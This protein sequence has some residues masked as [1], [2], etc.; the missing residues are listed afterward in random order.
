MDNKPDNHPDN[1][2]ANNKTGL[3]RELLP[4]VIIDL[5]PKLANL[6]I[7]YILRLNSDSRVV[8]DYIYPLLPLN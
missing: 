7:L 3:E 4:E 5:T 8:C 2:L 1:H 6:Y